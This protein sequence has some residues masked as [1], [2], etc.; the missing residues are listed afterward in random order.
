M[1]FASFSDGMKRRAPYELA[2]NSLFENRGLRVEVDDF[3]DSI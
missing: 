1:S 2:C 3:A